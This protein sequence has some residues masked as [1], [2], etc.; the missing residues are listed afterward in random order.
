MNNRPDGFGSLRRVMEES[1]PPP[2]PRSVGVTATNGAS[3]RT[4]IVFQFVS[5][6]K[7]LPELKSTLQRPYNECRDAVTS[8]MNELGVSWKDEGQG[9]M[10]CEHGHRG[11]LDYV[12]FSIQWITNGASSPSPP[13]AEMW[14]TKVYINKVSGSGQAFRDIGKQVLHA[15]KYTIQGGVRYDFSTITWALIY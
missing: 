2:A 14:Y 3:T 5:W 6:L 9:Y 7:G 13:G 4:S 12:E 8:K 11:T 15:A 10:I 1:A